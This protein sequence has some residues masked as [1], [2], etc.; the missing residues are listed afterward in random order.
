MLSL[1]H[2]HPLEILQSELRA[3]DQ[4]INS[5][6]PVWQ[7]RFD[8]M[9]QEHAFILEADLPGVNQESLKIEVHEDLLTVRGERLGFDG[10]GTLLRRERHCGSFERS[11]RLSE[12]VSKE[13]IHAQM[14]EG[15]LRLELKKTHPE[16]PKTI[17][18]QF[19]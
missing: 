11:F 6:A 7:P 19:H 12:K 2:R 14:R 18:V 9:E 4:M 17:E 13:T 8:I 10:E 5:S 1:F 3:Q 15:V 16:E